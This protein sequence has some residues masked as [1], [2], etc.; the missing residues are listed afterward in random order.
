[1]MRLS[2]IWSSLILASVLM[3]GGFGLAYA[4]V[5]KISEGSGQLVTT[6]ALAQDG[7]IIKLDPGIYKGNFILDKSIK[8]LGQK[9]VTFDGQGVGTVIKIVAPDV[10]VFGIYIIGSG[11]DHEK[12]DSGIF[13]DKFADRAHVENN[14]LEGNLI[15]VYVW[16]QQDAKVIHNKIIGRRDH[17]INSRGNGIYV[18]N[19]PGAYVAYNDISYGR[20]GIF[21]NA[22]KNNRFIGNRFENLRFAVHYMYTHDSEVSDNVSINNHAGY[23]LM[24]SDRLIVKHNYSYGDKEHGFLLNYANKSQFE[25]NKVVKSANK[26]VFIYNS[27]HNVFRGNWFEGCAIGIHFTGGSES[28]IMSGNTFLNSQNQVKYVGTRWVEWSDNGVGNFW[29]D[30][31]AFDLNGDGISENSYKPNDLVDQ[32]IWRHPFAKSL[33]TSPTVKMLRW[34]QGQFPALYPGGVIDSNPLMV[35]HQPILP[36]LWAVNAQA[37]IGEIR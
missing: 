23:S 13:I 26:C 35:P 31:P 34:A 16:G 7:D 5:L 2:K 15:G 25:E 9:G 18:W 12:S 20:D 33:L 30:N 24:F 28:N 32:M 14:F 8:L 17:R 4:D 1:M 36:T 29:S 22:S 19:A 6:L 10:T 3:V 37:E 11:S 27:N 21:V